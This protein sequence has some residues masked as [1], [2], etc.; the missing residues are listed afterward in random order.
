MGGQQGK[1]LVVVEY[2]QLIDIAD[3]RLSG[4]AL[5]PADEFEAVVVRITDEFEQRT[6]LELEEVAIHRGIFTGSFLGTEAFRA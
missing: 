5:F 2:P 1:G 6:V 3:V 4:C